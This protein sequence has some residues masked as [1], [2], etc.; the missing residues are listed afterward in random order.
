MSF[1]TVVVVSFLTSK[2]KIHSLQ[3]GIHPTHHL[4]AEHSSCT[5]WPRLSADGKDIKFTFIEI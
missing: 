5:P 4:I 2:Q 1:V 3:D